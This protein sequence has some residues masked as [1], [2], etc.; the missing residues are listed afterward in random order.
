MATVKGSRAYQYKLVKYRP[1]LWA[2]IATVITAAVLIAVQASWWLG[3]KQGMS[4]QEEALDDLAQAKRDLRSAQ[5]SHTELRQRLANIKLGSEVDKNALEVI[6]EEV[7]EL[8]QAIAQLEEENQFYRNL[9]A[10]T[11]NKRGLTFGVVE[12]SQTDRPR[13][14]RYKVVM[15]QLA[16]QHN[17]LNG[18]LNINIVGRM[19]GNLRVFA[20]KELTSGMDSTNIKL[21]FK[22]FQNIEGE[23]VLPQGFEPE[24]IELEARSTGSNAVTV[25]KRLGW[26]V[27]EPV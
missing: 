24:R 1:T 26:L 5:Q 7:T 11:D 16:T 22:Y 18:T 15:Q 25:E 4:Q 9:M 21:R 8:K 2:I 17:L 3:H 14:Y 19:D 10:P 27:E 6:R 23:L 12:I 20:L 13:T